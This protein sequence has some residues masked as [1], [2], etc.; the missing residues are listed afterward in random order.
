MAASSATALTAKDSC[1]RRLLLR[2][3]IAAFGTGAAAAE[4]SG[5]RRFIMSR[6]ELGGLGVLADVS[7]SCCSISCCEAGSLW[8]MTCPTKWVVEALASRS[9]LTSSASAAL[10]EPAEEDPDGVEIFGV[11]EEN[12]D[13]DAL[14][15][16]GRPL[17]IG[18][19][20]EDSAERT[21]ERRASSWD[22]LIVCVSS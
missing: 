10:V 22:R 1:P 11:S 8:L 5:Y 14:P 13:D 6:R 4:E 2:I 3:L 15:D 12:P 17:G 16:D 9:A 18:E 7:V 20:D 19:A 21:A